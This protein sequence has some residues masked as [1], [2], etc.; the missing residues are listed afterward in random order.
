MPAEC[1]VNNDV[2]AD[3]ATQSIEVSGWDA[4]GQFFVE[5]AEMDINDSGNATTR[6]CHRVNSGSLVFVRLV[7]GQGRDA[8]EKSHPTANEAHATEAPDFDGR[9]RIRLTPCQ[10]RASRNPG[11][12]T[13]APR[14]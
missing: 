3:S 7:Y 14:I 2:A 13:M 9:C 10:P 12:Q 11:D 8:R 6:L 4:E 5:I 1:A